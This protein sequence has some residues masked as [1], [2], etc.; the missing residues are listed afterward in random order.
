MYVADLA[1]ASDLMKATLW[2]WIVLV[3]CRAAPQKQSRSALC[4]ELRA[5][6][7][8]QDAK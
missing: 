8:M 3:M 6:S 5:F 4:S 7:L 2:S 1:M